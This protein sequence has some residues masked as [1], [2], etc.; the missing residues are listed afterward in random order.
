MRPLQAAGDE[1]APP[2][3]LAVR[4][5]GAS[6]KGSWRWMGT[7]ALVFAPETRLP[8]ATE[9]VVTVPA[10]TRSLAGEALAAPF[11]S[12]FGSPARAKFVQ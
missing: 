10:E 8:D 2:A 1:S 5:A 12:P 9:Y 3:R 6:P 4:G 7:N 11:E